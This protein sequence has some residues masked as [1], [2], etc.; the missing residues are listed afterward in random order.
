MNNAEIMLIKWLNEKLDWKVSADALEKTPEKYILVDR[1]GGGR[2]NRIMDNA[3][4]FIEV[5]HKTSRVEASEMAQHIVDILPDFAE[6]EPV[7]K[8]DV[9]S[10]ISLDDL[11]KK[12]F[13]YQIYLNLKVRR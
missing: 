3:E 12:F 5:Y 10:L 7:A 6:L 8:V 9:N 4:I 11:N 1:T 2:E 13:R